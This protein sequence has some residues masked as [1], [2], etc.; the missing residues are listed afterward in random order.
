MKKKDEQLLDA[1]KT[2]GELLEI[3]RQLK[4]LKIQVKALEGKIK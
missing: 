2:S 1:G 3:Y 4:L